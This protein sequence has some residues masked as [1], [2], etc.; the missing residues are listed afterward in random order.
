MGYRE[1]YR[2][3]VDRNWDGSP[4]APNERV[5][6]VFSLEAGS[7]AVEVDAPFYGDPPPSGPAGEKDGLWNHEVVELFLLG[8]DGRYLE[9]ELGPHG[10]FLILELHGVR[11]VSGRLAPAYCATRIDG[12][13]WHGLL[14]LTPDAALLPFTHANGYAMHDEENTRRHLAASPVPGERPDF[15][16]P[17]RFIPLKDLT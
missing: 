10:H 15:H 3:N 2:L 6:I 5:E 13:R 14:K 16:Q 1:T 9:I 8:K 4:A 7:V 17:A 12:S 11:K